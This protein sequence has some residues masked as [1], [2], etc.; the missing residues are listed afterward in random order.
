MSE[1]KI[2][3]ANSI[4]VADVH[5]VVHFLRHGQS[6]TEFADLMKSIREN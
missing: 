5:G 2:A 6:I 1:G 4:H 3:I